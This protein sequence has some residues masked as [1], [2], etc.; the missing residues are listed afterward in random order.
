VCAADDDVLDLGLFIARKHHVLPTPFDRGR[1]VL[2]LVLFL[3]V[4]P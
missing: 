3:A 4:L 2:L 1:S